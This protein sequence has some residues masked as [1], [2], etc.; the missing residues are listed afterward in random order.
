MIDPAFRTR[1]DAALT[2]LERR[3]GVRVLLAVESG[4]RAWGFASRDSD[5]DVRFLYVR[6][7]ADYLSVLPPR[8]VIEQPID[9]A[10]DLGGWDLRKALSLIVRSN[11]VVLEWLGSPVVY[12]RDQ[13]VAAELTTLAQAAAHLPALA[14]HYDRLARGAW[15]TGTGDPIRLKSYLYALRPALALLWLRQR[16]APPPMDL[17]A[18]L[19]G[20][21]LPQ[22]VTR[23]IEHLQRRKA[24]ATEADVTD[25]Q[26][27]LEDFLSE[28]LHTPEP[29]P[30]AWDRTGTLG[31]A[32][33][34]FR[35]LVGG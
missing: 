22:T 11:A 9:D 17:P 31:K 10:L 14:Y 7:V 20:I 26:S 2:E 32:N 5:Y 35:R 8:D 15:T 34:L 27:V 16:G 13:A 1:A 28:V 33:S 18:L 29:R 4:S 21:T 3:E 30:A 12:R 24:D 6:P 19:V 23:E 25:R